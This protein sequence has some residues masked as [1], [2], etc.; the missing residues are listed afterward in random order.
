MPSQAPSTNFAKYLDIGNAIVSYSP[1]AKS[2]IAAAQAATD[3]RK[4]GVLKSGIQIAIAKQVVDIVSGTPKKLQKRFFTDES[5]KITGDLLELSPFNLSRVLGGATITTTLKASAPAPT[6]V[7]S[8]STKSSVICA[9]VT[10]FTVDK[11]VKVGS[12]FGVIKAINTG[13]KTLTFYEDLDGDT[14]P[15]VAEAVSQV[16]TMTIAMGGVAAP[17]NCALKISKTSVSGMGSFDLYI[18]SALADGSTNLNYADGDNNDPVSLPFSFDAV[19]DPLV[20]D[21]AFAAGTFTL[22]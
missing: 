9:A 7:A 17:T 10:G 3:W 16:A 2:S 22:S 4:L 19:S 11:L 18:L 14:N 21:G 1:L 13:T 15:T 8:G 6:T 20:E 12:Q 5:M